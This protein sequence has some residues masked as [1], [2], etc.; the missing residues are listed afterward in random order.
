MPLE[1]V[2]NLDHGMRRARPTPGQ[3]FDSRD[4]DGGPVLYQ[5]VDELAGTDDPDPCVI[6]DAAAE[7]TDVESDDGDAAQDKATAAT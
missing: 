4:D 5:S 3:M 1:L 6:E 2:E 7:I